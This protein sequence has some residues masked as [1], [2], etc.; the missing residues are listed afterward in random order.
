MSQHSSSN[1]RLSLSGK[2]E[3]LRWCR[4]ITAPFAYLYV[5]Q[6]HRIASY[7]LTHDIELLLMM[8]LLLLLLLLVVV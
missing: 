7:P 1:Y 6:P 4:E 3:L 5:I 8:M 2:D